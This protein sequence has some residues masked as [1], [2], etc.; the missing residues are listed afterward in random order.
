MK[1]KT[2]GSI[3]RIIEFWIYRKKEVYDQLFPKLKEKSYCDEKKKE[4]QSPKNSIVRVKR[5]TKGEE[6]KE[7]EEEFFV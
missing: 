6:G 1:K 3:Y 5:S 2:R 4:V 7:E